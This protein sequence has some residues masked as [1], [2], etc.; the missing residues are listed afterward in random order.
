MILKNHIYRDLILNT[1]YKIIVNSSFI[2]LGINIFILLYLNDKLIFYKG[3]KMDI[4]FDQYY[5]FKYDFIM[6]S[7]FIS[8]AI[9]FI[10]IALKKL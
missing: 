5:N 2:Y 3:M 7:F 1:I 6:I 8:L 10:T 4:S 9:T